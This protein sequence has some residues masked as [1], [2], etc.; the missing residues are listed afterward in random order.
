MRAPELEAHLLKTEWVDGKTISRPLCS[1][2][3]CSSGLAVLFVVPGTGRLL[4]AGGCWSRCEMSDPMGR[5]EL[6]SEGWKTRCREQD[7]R[8]CQQ[9]LGWCGMSHKLQG[10]IAGLFQTGLQ[11]GC[12]GLRWGDSLQEPRTGVIY[13]S[14]FAL[15]KDCYRTEGKVWT[16]YLWIGRYMK[17]YGKKDVARMHREWF[18]MLYCL[19]VQE[20]Q[21][22]QSSTCISVSLKGTRWV[23]DPVSRV[24]LRG[25]CP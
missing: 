23:G 16:F 21:S 15:I 17:V 5:V 13:P 11:S 3:R 14:L 7:N 20:E 8:R 10:R 12:Q 24:E 25:H 22:P 9:V 18:F 6:N 2:P 19:G 4:S 1:H